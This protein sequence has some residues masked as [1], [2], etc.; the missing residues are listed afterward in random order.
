MLN[1]FES[2]IN[3]FDSIIANYLQDSHGGPCQV[4]PAGNFVSFRTE[5]S[6]VSIN[7]IERIV[8]EYR[9]SKNEINGRTKRE[10][11]KAVREE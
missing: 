11:E 7:R 2:W 8:E 10:I 9:S 6:L 1:D 3:K 4:F 5:E